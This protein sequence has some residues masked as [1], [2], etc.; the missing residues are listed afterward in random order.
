MLARQAMVGLS[1]LQRRGRLPRTAVSAI[2][3]FINKCGS[4]GVGGGGGAASSKAAHCEC[5]EVTG[6]GGGG[7]W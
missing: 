4:A 2:C 5:A 6:G 1:Q 3:E 7:G